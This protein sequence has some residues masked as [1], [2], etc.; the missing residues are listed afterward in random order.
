M[1]SRTLT[2]NFIGM[3]LGGYVIIWFMQIAVAEDI[4]QLSEANSYKNILLGIHYKLYT[5]CMWKE[6]YKGCI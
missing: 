3:Y 5:D 2:S 6:V 4:W 1:Y